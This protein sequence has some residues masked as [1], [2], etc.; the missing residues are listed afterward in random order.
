MGIRTIVVAGGVAVGVIPAQAQPQPGDERAIR[1]LIAQ[2]DRAGPV[3]RMDDAIV[4]TGPPTV[5]AA[6]LVTP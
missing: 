3:A 5:G 1:E 6:F 2:Q 4:R